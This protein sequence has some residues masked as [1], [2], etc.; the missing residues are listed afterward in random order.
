MVARIL[1]YPFARP[2]NRY[3]LANGMHIIRIFV[4]LTHI[5]ITLPNSMKLAINAD[6]CNLLEH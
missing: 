3:M 5:D 1:L 4:K 2:A 6:I